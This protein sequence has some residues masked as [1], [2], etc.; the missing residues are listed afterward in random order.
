MMTPPVPPTDSTGIAP[1]HPAQAV[2]DIEDG[3]GRIMG[4]RVLYFKLLRRF[5]HDHHSAPHQIRL[6]LGAG[7]FAQARLRAHT[8][9]GA[10]GMVGARTVY[11]LATALETALR[12]H[13]DALAQPLAEIELAL[14]ALLHAISSILPRVSEQH[15]APAAV[16][17]PDAPATLTLLARLARLLR[18]GDGAAI[19]VL[20][21]SATVL[22]ASLGLGTY[23]EVAAAAHEFDFDAAWRALTRRRQ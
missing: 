22:A 11:A 21:S 19:D 18:E 2:L 7:Q 20:E 10:A 16:P 9:K 14:T 17:D 1:A 4:D 13:A 6:A 8:L 3:L 23:Q 12:A 15:A 5:Q